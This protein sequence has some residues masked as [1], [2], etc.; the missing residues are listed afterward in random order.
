VGSFDI[1]LIGSK[2]TGH[3]LNPN[4]MKSV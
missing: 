3:R 1:F 4:L 2:D